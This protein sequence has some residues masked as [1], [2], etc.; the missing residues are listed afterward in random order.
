LPAFEDTE[1]ALEPDN[2]R[3]VVVDPACGGETVK[4]TNGSNISAVT[5]GVLYNMI[6]QIGSSA[7]TV[8]DFLL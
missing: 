4:K 3:R 8:T 6:D 1:F 2:V 5:P 7:M